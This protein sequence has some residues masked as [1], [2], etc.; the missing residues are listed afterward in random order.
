[1]VPGGDIFGHEDRSVALE[2]HIVHTC[3]TILLT[4]FVRIVFRVT[5]SISEDWLGLIVVRTPSEPG[6]LGG[7]EANFMLVSHSFIEVEMC[8]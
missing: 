7:L 4:Q 1:M 2:V 3:V 6:M 5:V 8:H